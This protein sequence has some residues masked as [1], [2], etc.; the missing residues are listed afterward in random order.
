MPAFESLNVTRVVRQLF[1][2]SR[3]AFKVRRKDNLEK[4]FTVNGLSK[5]RM[6]SRRT[7]GLETQLDEKHFKDLE[8]SFIS[9]AHQAK[10]WLDW[11]TLENLGE[12]EDLGEP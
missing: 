8:E 6:F 10:D 7:W 1:C 11:W 5:N 12:L 3:R 2:D 9:A 4:H